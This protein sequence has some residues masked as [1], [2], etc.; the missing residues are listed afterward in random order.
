M[1]QRHQ[2]E[3]IAVTESVP[4]V[5][6][7]QE[8]RNTLEDGSDAEFNEAA[9]LMDAE[10]QLARPYPS[11]PAAFIPFDV[12]SDI[13]ASVPVFQVLRKTNDEHVAG[14]DV[15]IDENLDLS[16]I[17]HLLDPGPT[18]IE[19]NLIASTD[20]FHEPRSPNE[21]NSD[22]MQDSDDDLFATVD[23][24]EVAELS[25]ESAVVKE[26]SGFIVQS[27]SQPDLSETPKSLSLQFKPQFVEA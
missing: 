20:A 26:I 2:R 11:P 7:L 5:Q 13:E 15:P 22:V 12:L 19:A 6:Q 14:D 16:G 25:S 8:G 3:K 18:G 9:R 27:V 24:P 1:S 21:E 10:L 4:Q 17:E 23:E